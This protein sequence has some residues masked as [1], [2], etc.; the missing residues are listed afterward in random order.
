MHYLV[1]WFHISEK[2]KGHADIIFSADRSFFL[3]FFLKVDLDLGNYERFLDI[4]LTRDNNITTGKIYQ[5]IGQMSPNPCATKTC[6]EDCTIK[7][8]VCLYTS[9][10][11][12][13]ERREK[14]VFSFLNLTLTNPRH[15]MDICKSLSI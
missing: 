2:E 15:S 6:V 4:K 1:A 10:F 7:S 14:V 5:V 11:F 9:L 12:F 3:L 13:N 8:K